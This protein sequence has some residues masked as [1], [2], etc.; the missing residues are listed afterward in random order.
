[1]KTK[2]DNLITGKNQTIKALYVA[3]GIMTVVALFNGAGWMASP[4]FLRVHIPPDITNGAVLRPG[5]AG[6]S[7][8]YA[9]AYYIWQQLYR[10]EKDGVTD[11]EDK[12]HALRNYLTPGCFQDRL[13]DFALRKSRHELDRRERSLWEIPGR[14]FSTE[15]VHVQARNASWVVYLDLHIEETMLGESVKDRLVN[16]PIRVVRYDVDPEQNPFGLAV[17]CLTGTPRA[18]EVAATE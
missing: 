17:D 11:Y 9:F 6:K 18:I 2:Y 15:R 13:D 4:K 14:G 7:D 10:W 1:M 16:Y 3:L 12:I 8:V 5:D